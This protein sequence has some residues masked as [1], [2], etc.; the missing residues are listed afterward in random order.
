MK[1]THKGSSANFDT[2]AG[3]KLFPPKNVEAD[4]S[5]NDTEDADGSGNDSNAEGEVGESSRPAKYDATGSVCPPLP[6]LAGVIIFI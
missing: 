2:V 6:P 5:D 1:E 4:G 3:V